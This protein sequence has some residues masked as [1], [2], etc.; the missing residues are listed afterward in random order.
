M[1]SI[2]KGTLFILCLLLF[3]APVPARRGVLLPGDPTR[4]AVAQIPLLPEYFSI[5]SVPPVPAPLTEFASPALDPTEPLSM[6]PF[7]EGEC[8]A[9]S[10]VIVEPVIEP[11]Q[12]VVDGPISPVVLLEPAPA[13]LPEPVVEPEGQ[14]WLK[15]ELKR[16][17]DPD[18]WQ[19]YLTMQ[20]RAEQKTSLGGRDRR[21]GRRILNAF[22]VKREKGEERRKIRKKWTETFGVDIWYP[23]FKVKEVER[24][25]KKRFTFRIRKLKCKPRVK[26]GLANYICEKRF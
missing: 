23:Y 6:P 19:T 20:E 22:Y 16:I 24:W 3:V 18:P 12:A 9:C 11:I 15:E 14:L 25:V 17:F 8:A 5:A 21:T 26:R 2:V 1:K 4:P 10:G 7:S 13:L